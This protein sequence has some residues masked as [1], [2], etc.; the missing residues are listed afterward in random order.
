MARGRKRKGFGD[1]EVD[2][3]EDKQNQYFGRPLTEFPAG[4]SLNILVRLS[5]KRILICKRVCK[6]WRTIVSS[7]EFA[8]LHFARGEAF[9]LVRSAAP[10]RVSRTLYLVEPP[11]HCSGFDDGP[12]K[13]KLDTKLKIPVY[14]EETV[15]EMDP[16]PKSGVKLRAEHHE[17]KIANSCNGLLCLCEPTL[18]FPFEVWRNPIAVCNPITSEYINLPDPIEWD[19][20]T[21]RSLSIHCGLGFSPKM[22]QYKVIRFREPLISWE[23]E[24]CSMTEIHTLGTGSWKRVRNVPSSLYYNNGSPTYLNG[25]LHWIYTEENG[26]N[27]IV[28][29]NFDIEKFQSVPPPPF[30]LWKIDKEMT[31]E[32]VLGVLGGCLCVC[33]GSGFEK[34][35]IWVMKEYGVQE[36]WSKEFCF[37]TQTNEGRWIY[38]TYDP[39][40]LLRNGAVVLFHSSSGAL[41]YHDPKKHGFKFLKPQDGYKSPKYVAIA[42]IPSFIS[43]K[44]VVKGHN[45]AVLPT[46]SRCA[47]FKLQG[48]CKDVF[49]VEEDPAMTWF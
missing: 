11:E 26:S 46:K 32:W 15:I 7:P 3:V 40:C 27:S 48:E 42:H 16:P 17:L 28:S 10:S 45:M 24:S 25:S 36:S 41:F 4:I 33:D 35:K 1:K 44:D 9:P 49:L 20:D 19:R 37:I 47:E 12:I 21:K 31:G 30:K 39:I 2:G 29:F 8:K 22:N 18:D 14:D 13:M 38:G 6:T 5:V 34:L 43:L 23:R